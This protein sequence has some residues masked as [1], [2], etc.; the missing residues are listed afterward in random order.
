MFRMTGSMIT[1]VVVGDTRAS[2]VE[3]NYLGRN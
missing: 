1:D 3:N 2:A